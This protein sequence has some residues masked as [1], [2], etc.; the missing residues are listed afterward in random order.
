M[1]KILY[2]ALCNL[3]DKS[4]GVSKK[5]QM[6]LS[7]FKS[8]GMI[9][10]CIAYGNDG[11]YLYGQDSSKIIAPFR[12]FIPRRITLF[13]A[14]LQHVKRYKYDLSYIR[15]PYSDYFFILVIKKLKKQ[16][17]RIFLEIP[18]Y[19]IEYPILNIRSLPK[20]LLYLQDKAFCRMLKNYIYRCFS[21]GNYTERIFN[22]KCTNMPNGINISDFP[23]TI[24]CGE[25][26]KLNIVSVSGFYL[27]H[28]F[29]RLI[30]GLVRYY[31]NFM[32]GKI[33][34]YLHM[35]GEGPEKH[36]LEQICLVKG[37]SEYVIF[38]GKMS[39]KP[40]DNL[41]NSCNMACGSLALHREGFVTASPLKTKE[42]LARGIPFIYAY[43][44]I[45]LPENYPYALQLPANDDAIDF[46]QIIDFYNNYIDHYLEVSYNMRHFAKENYSWDNIFK[47]NCNLFS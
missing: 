20:L 34:I 17:S 42:Y 25:K 7:A 13:Y 27:H 28:G 3:Q 4:D 31:R 43:K 40:L 37:I 19:P 33:K 14:V 24:Y 18:S 46:N 12:E 1:K 45:G 2:I 44:E 30:L 21:V 6:Q 35:V 39:G 23:K 9:S 29:D 47:V 38:Y 11:C 32:S 41:F 10:H 5:I 15:Y 36:K 8:N 22:I 16:N 26:D